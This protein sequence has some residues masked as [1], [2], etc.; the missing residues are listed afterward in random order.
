MLFGALLALFVC[1]SMLVRFELAM[2]QMINNGLVIVSLLMCVYVAYVSGS[3]RSALANVAG[4]YFA[5]MTLYIGSYAL[6]TSVFVDSLAW[7]PFWERDYIYHGF[8]SVRS[9][10]DHGSN[11]RDLLVLQIIS[12]IICSVMYF[13]AGLVGFGIKMLLPR[14]HTA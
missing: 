6:M 10:M 9:Y 13:V 5:I 1:M 11:F 12:C 8:T 3:I 4:Y 7:V 2:W 14:F